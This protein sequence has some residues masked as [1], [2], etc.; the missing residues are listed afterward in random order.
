MQVR[1]RGVIFSSAKR[2][3]IGFKARFSSQKKRL[4]HRSLQNQPV[5][6]ESKPAIPRCFFHIMFLGA[7]KRLFNFIMLARVTQRSATGASRR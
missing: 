5:R 4:C 1:V 3:N 2:P 6:V 7:S